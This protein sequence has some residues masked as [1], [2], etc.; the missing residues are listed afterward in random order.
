[1]LAIP[2]LVIFIVNCGNDDLRSHSTETTV[3]DC[4]TKWQLL[5]TADCE[6]LST[7]LEKA[8]ASKYINTYTRSIVNTFYYILSQCTINYQCSITM[9]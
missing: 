5:G 7:I 2:Q 1:M 9:S 3:K 4:Y 8:K 6:T